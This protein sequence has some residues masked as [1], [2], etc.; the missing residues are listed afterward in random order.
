MVEIE[1]M[2]DTTE[3]P[4]SQERLLDAAA[5]EDVAASMSRPSAKMHLEALAQKLR[6]ESAALKRVEES[7]ANL[8][9]ASLEETTTAP[10]STAAARSKDTKAPETAPPSKP[11]PPPCMPTAMYAPIDKFSFDAGG[12]N[13]SH[14]TLYIPLP[15]VGSIP[16]ENITCNFTTSS[17]DL[18]VKD[19]AG[20]SY[21]LFKDNLEKDIDPDN[22]KFLV[23]AD[24]IV[25]KLGKV[26]SEYGSYDFWTEL[27]AKKK[28]TGKKED[29]AASI[30][31][32]MKD[33]YES[34]DD[35]MKKMIGETMMKQRR[36]ELND[37]MKGVGGLDDL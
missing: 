17:F 1:E 14:I 27:T 18:I 23:K 30:M 37:P 9:E 22:S 11:P 12:Y 15:S 6:R 25:L 31:D 21:R 33:M 34:G 20:K 26:K 10:D 4:P 13:S 5:I 19:L 24:K 29:P 35:K 28:K 32:L 3:V 8:G 2:K 7:K 36:G 16:R